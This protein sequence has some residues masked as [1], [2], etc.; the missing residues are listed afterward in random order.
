LAPHD[1]EQ[2]AA[3]Q[4][5]RLRLGLATKLWP[6]KPVKSV[7]CKARNDRPTKEAALTGAQTAEASMARL[8]HIADF[9]HP[10]A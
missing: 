4:T 7:P 2:A 10:K 6:A 5:A 3:G 9:M 8:R 1:G